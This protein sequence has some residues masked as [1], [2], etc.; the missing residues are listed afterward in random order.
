[1][2]VL[3][4]PPYLGRSL[5]DKEQQQDMDIVFNGLK[6]Y[7]D[8]D[9]ICCWF[10]QASRYIHNFNAKFAFVTTNSISQGIQIGLLWP[11]IFRLRLS[12]EFCY[13]SFKWTNNAKGN[14]GVSVVIIGITNE[15]KNL[16]KRIYSEKWMKEVVNIEVV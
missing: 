6:N 16:I 10:M 9:Y 1:M 7:K 8:L 12:I 14:A 5:R 2:Y 13:T 11:H 3:G 15:S 4:N